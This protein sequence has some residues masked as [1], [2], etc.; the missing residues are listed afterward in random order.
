M[1]VT[2]EGVRETVLTST[3]SP[4][5][6][7]DPF[8]RVRE[9]LKAVS[10]AGVAGRVTVVMPCFNAAEFV[11]AAIESVLTQDHPD[12]ELVVVDDQSTDGSLD[13]VTSYGDRLVLIRR[14]VRGGA[15][16]AR[17]DGLQVA[18]GERIQF[19]D[20]DDLLV[21]GA[22][23]ALWARCAEGVTPFGERLEL[24]DDLRPVPSSRLRGWGRTEPL[25]FML[26]KGIPPMAPLHE[27]RGIY[28]VGGFDESLPQA[29]E[30][31]LHI[32]LVLHGIRFADTGGVVGVQRMHESPTRISNCVWADVDPM[33][34]FDLSMHWLDLVEQTVGPARAT[35][36]RAVACDRLVEA[37]Q[38]AWDFGYPDVSARYLELITEH[39]PEYRFGALS[40]IVGGVD[41]AL[42]RRAIVGA[43]LP[44]RL[45][46]RVRQLVRSVAIRIGSAR[47]QDGMVDAVESTA[48]TRRR[49]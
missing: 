8:G 34:H 39:F 4:P 14:E 30:K 29:Q 22:I 21:P 49:S 13:V 5:G 9:S 23:A 1:A 48:G 43:T 12:V 6:W 18:T 47:R 25:E 32:R 46:R 31:D 15:C 20:A 19:L 2:A 36:Y 24:W 10:D 44:Q 35:E 42:G 38:R 28:A 37:A 3:S 26:R 11:G 16:A 45:V 7:I 17:N 33:R 40:R 27:R 41:S